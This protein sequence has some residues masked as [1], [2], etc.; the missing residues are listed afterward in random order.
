MRNN[1]KLNAKN[2]KYRTKIKA[3]ENLKHQKLKTHH[4]NITYT[5]Y[6]SLKD[7]FTA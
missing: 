7:S 6:R 1:R 5:N 2:T 4:D 3:K